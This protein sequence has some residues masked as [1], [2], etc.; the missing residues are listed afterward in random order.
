MQPHGLQP[1]GSSVHGSLLARILEWGAIFSPGYFPT[2]GIES[3]SPA[4]ADGFFTT[5][6]PGKPPKTPWN[7][8]GQNTAVGSYSLLQGI[9]PNQGSNSGLLHCRQI[10]YQL[11]HQ[12][13]PRI[14]KWAAYPFSRGSPQPRKWTKV[15]QLIY[16]KGPPK[17]IEQ[18]K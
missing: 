16:E 11:S 10:L 18:V 12:G 14:P 17:L 3:S 1:S 9:Y 8:P 6:P 15:S 13:S 4:L 5:E 7:S 2:Q